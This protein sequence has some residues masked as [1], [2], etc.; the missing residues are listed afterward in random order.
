[1]NKQKFPKPGPDLEPKA[2]FNINLLRKTEN[3]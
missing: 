3:S 1:M 2:Q